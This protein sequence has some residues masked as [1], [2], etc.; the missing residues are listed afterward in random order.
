MNN[1]E[2]TPISFES[3]LPPHEIFGLFLTDEEMEII[4]LK[5]TSYARLKGEHNVTMTLDKLKALIAILLV[6]GYTEPPRQE[7]CWERREDGY[8]LLLSSMMSKNKFEECQRYLLLIDDNK[9][10]IDDWFVEGRPL[11]NSIN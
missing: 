4:S 2:E 1:W 11:L 9:L 3:N 10:D 7:M 5:S 6:S 8:M